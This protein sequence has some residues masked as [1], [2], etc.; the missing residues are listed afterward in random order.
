MKSSF[1]QKI[2]IFIFAIGALV[3]FA[4]ALLLTWANFELP[5]YFERSYFSVSTPTTEKLEL[6]CPL[7]LTTVDDGAIKAYLPNT[8]DKTINLDFR[9]Q[10]SF[11]EGIERE[12]QF[13]PEVLSGETGVVDV[14]IDS[15][16]RF[17]NMFILMRAFQFPTYK[18]PARAGSCAVVMLPFNFVDGSEALLLI[19]GILILFMGGGLLLFARINK[20]LVKKNKSIFNS[21][22]VTT[23]FIGIAIAAGVLS[24]WVLGIIMLA[25]IFL[26][27][28]AV[29]IFFG[30]N[31]RKNW[32]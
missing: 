9:V 16:D 11:M 3:G 27:T 12:L 10:V 30:D 17:Y 2:G 7:L 19:L 18:T 24:Y 1:I 23:V 32:R 29:F 20:P 31:E 13:N 15:A 6:S 5:F 26:Q 14:K 21:M 4:M 28:V 22:V 25:V 8:T